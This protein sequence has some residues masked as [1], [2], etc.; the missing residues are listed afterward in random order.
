LTPI[1]PHTAEEIWS[2]LEHEPEEFVQL[3]ELPD[4]LTFPNEEEILDTWTAFMNF[5]SQAQ[6]ALEEARNEKVIGKSLE[7][8]VTIYPNEQVERYL[9]RLIATLRNFSLF[10]N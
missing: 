4:A 2:Y 10:L 8:K 3:A 6:K 1:L 9:K 7:A 5:R